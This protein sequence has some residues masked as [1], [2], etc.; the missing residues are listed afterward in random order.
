MFPYTET[1]KCDRIQSLAKWE[2]KERKGKKERRK[3]RERKKRKRDKEG[4][5]E[6]ERKKER[7][8]ERNKERER[9][10]KKRK[11]RN[12]FPTVKKNLHNGL[13]QK[14]EKLRCKTTQKYAISA[15]RTHTKIGLK[16][17]FLFKK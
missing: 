12:I 9:E 16:G 3:E 7:D 6:R 17:T 14:A 10:R 13:P 4:R 8:R 11:E 5:K 1:L 15:A 2:E